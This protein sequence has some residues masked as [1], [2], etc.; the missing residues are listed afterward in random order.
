[1]RG[2][3]AR[4]RGSGPARLR[5]IRTFWVLLLLGMGAGAASADEPLGRLFFTPAERAQLDAARERAIANARHP[6][7][8]PV[9]ERPK[10]PSPRTMT[11]DG[12]VRRSDGETTVWVNGAPVESGTGRSDVTVHRVERN[13]V[14]IRLPDTGRSV[15]IKVGQTVEATSG[16]VEDS[17]NRTPPD[18]RGSADGSD[19]PAREGARADAPPRGAGDDATGSETDA[20]VE[21]E[22]P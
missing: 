8:Q 9:N 6:E 18:P 7:K 5:Q 15:R 4:R 12:V 22:R 11:L 17:F 16:R 14:G 1:M 13:S 20:E 2:A 3:P 10:T 21:D 19:A